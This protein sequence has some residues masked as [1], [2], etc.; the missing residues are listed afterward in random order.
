MKINKIIAVVLVIGVAMLTACFEKVPVKELS[1]AKNA[2]SEAESVKADYYAKDEYL[3]SKDL[4]LKAHDNVKNEEYDKAKQNALDSQKKAK[5]AYDKALPLLAK[6]TLDVA[7][8]SLQAADDAYAAVLA[9]E[10]YAKANDMLQEAG[11]QYENKNYLATYKAA[12]DA[13]MYAKNARNVAMNQKET[14][15]DSIKEVNI[16]IAQAESYGATQYAPEKL[17]LA[18]EHSQVARMAYE[19]GELKKGFSA[20]EVA[21]LNADDAYFISL[22][23]T[24][25]KKIEEA[26]TAIQ[27][28]KGS[29]AAQLSSS[30]IKAAE[31]SLE[32]AKTLFNDAKY[33]ESMIAAGQAISIAQGVSSKKAVAIAPVIEQ[34]A[35]ETAVVKEEP[36][37]ALQKKV[38]EE[39]DYT[40]YKV[41]YNPAKRD[42]LWRIAEKF[43]NDGF[44][45]KVIFET[46]RDIVKNPDLIKPGWMLKIPKTATK[47]TQPVKPVKDEGKQAV[48]K[49]KEPP[50]TELKMKTE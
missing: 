8:Q 41:K 40:L 16:V 14:L 50:A 7:T 44:K 36:K 43:Y 1:L 13:D 28:A 33:K 45:W 42:C 32:Q 34:Q 6:D 25:A 23:A 2:I 10:D 15:A 20:V 12:L 27:T 37:E 21:K 46:N 17:A 9:K 26:Q 3:L 19:T 5:E 47:I 18:K 38:E 30:D 22:K 24:A 48:I 39:T 49:E 4:L 35:K 31:E 11:K 29:Q